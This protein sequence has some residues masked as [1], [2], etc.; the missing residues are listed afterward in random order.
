MKVSYLTEAHLQQ[1][2]SNSFP[3]PPGG[4]LFKPAIL[5]MPENHY[6]ALLHGDSVG[7]GETLPAD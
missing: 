3:L 7:L 4:G 6:A 1:G 5:G 2:P